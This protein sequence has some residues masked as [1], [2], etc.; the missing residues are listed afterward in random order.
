MRHLPLPSLWLFTDPVRTPDPLALAARLPEGSGVVYRHFGKAD[1]VQEAE[2]LRALTRRRGLTLLIGADLELCLRTFAD[3]L[4]APEKGMQN[5]AR[6]RRSAPHLLLTV[7][8]HSASALRRSRVADAAFLSPIFP[9]A[10]P[11]A[12]R[13]IGLARATRMAA[14]S[15]VPVIGLGGVTPARAAAL[16]RRGFAGAAGI[17]MFTES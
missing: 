12:G 1:R 8:A 3:G 15:P 14:T 6:I 16:M 9:S 7:A 5:L 4:H 11:S 13:P 10:S 2:A 17:E